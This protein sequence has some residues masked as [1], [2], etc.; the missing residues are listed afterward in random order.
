[1][2]RRIRFILGKTDFGVRNYSGLIGIVP[3]AS[4]TFRRGTNMVPPVGRG[5]GPMRECP[6]RIG[7][8]AQGL[9]GPSRPNLGET[10][11]GA[12]RRGDY[13]PPTPPSLASGLGLGGGVRA[14]AHPSIYRGLGSTPPHTPPPQ[15]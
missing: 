1:M 4:R 13:L 8:G 15:P 3:E 10:L 11:G 5:H 2:V 14:G 12:S 6:G 9:I 7:P